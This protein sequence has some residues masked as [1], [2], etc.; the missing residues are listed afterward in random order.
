[1]DKEKLI[2]LEKRDDAP[3]YIKVLNPIAC[4]LL[5]FVFCG[6]V[7]AVLGN[8]PIT[9]YLS[10]FKGAFGSPKKIG[11]TMLYSIPLVLCSLSVATAFKM[12][13]S[14]IGAEGQMTMGCWACIGVGLFC[15]FIPTSLTLPAMILVGFLAGGIWAVISI[16]PK[17]LWN[18]NEVIVTLLMN[19]VAILFTEYFIYGPWRDPNGDN[20]PFTAQ[21]DATARL[22]KIWQNVHAG[23]IIALVC[24]V[25]LFILFKKTT[26]GYKVSV[27][28]ESRRSAQYA[29]INITKNILL[30]MLIG[31]GMAGL[32]G[33]CEVAGSMGMMK[34]NMANGVGYTAIII[35]YLSQFN[36]LMCVFVSVLF[37]GLSAGSL[38]M[39]ISGLPVQIVTMLQGAIL[40]FVLGGHILLNFRIRIRK[41]KKTTGSPNVKG[42]N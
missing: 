32:A 40:L 6:L 18:V 33:V 42:G 22:P 15:K 26:W 8:K 39:Q 4:V 29:G 35:A 3:V 5:A 12:K 30:T 19:Y 36:P 24:A 27:I 20:M 1:M 38:S 23:I 7:M 14:N 28:G 21:L 17:V 31:G 13:L 9:A 10:L 37:G 16:L 41:N 2:R 25:V 34:T 11:N